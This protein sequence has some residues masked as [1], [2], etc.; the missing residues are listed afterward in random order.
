MYRKIGDM[1]ALFDPYHKGG[2]HWMLV[3]IDLNKR[4]LV[5]IDPLGPPN[6]HKL[7]ETFAYHWLEWALFH[8]SN[9][10]ELVVPTELE[11]VTIEHALQRDSCNCGIF[12]M[13]VC[14]TLY[15]HHCTVS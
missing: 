3:F 2:N 12:T 14:N 6:E 11:V 13:C 8:N 10:P 9:C 4:Q 1:D 7:V 15:C 5:Y